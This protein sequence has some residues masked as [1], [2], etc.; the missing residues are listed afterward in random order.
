MADV[1]SS[2]ATIFFLRGCAAA[3]TALTSSCA[4]PAGAMHDQ[5]DGTNN[6]SRWQHAVVK[7]RL[8]KR[9]YLECGPSQHRPGKLSI[10]ATVTTN[11]DSKQSLH[12]ACVLITR[13]FTL[14]AVSQ[15]EYTRCRSRPLPARSPAGASPLPC[16]STR[17]GRA[18]TV[19]S[20]FF[21]TARRRST[22]HRCLS[23]APKK[24][25]NSGVTFALKLSQCKVVRV[26]CLYGRAGLKTLQWLFRQDPG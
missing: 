5:R 9:G 1:G 15:F 3:V 26:H 13:A 25:E 22:R 12:G 17:P 20:G 2:S 8:D 11:R 24:V 19:G 7:R 16:T 10:A 18:G 14:C 23:P 6:G 4:C 21:R